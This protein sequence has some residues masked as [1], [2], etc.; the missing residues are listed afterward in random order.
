[1]YVDLVY[2]YYNTDAIIDPDLKPMT[3]RK[4]L[5]SDVFSKNK[6]GIDLLRN[7][8]NKDK[9]FNFHININ[10]KLDNRDNKNENSNYDGNNKNRKS[11]AEDSPVLNI[12]LSSQHIAINSPSTH[13]INSCDRSEMSNRILMKLKDDKPGSPSRFALKKVPEKFRG[14]N[15]F[16]TGVQLKRNS[17]KKDIKILKHEETIKKIKVSDKN[18]KFSLVGTSSYRKPVQSKLYLDSLS[19]FDQLFLS[20]HCNKDKKNFFNTIQKKI[21][22]KLSIEYLF[23]KYHEVNFLKSQFEEEIIDKPYLVVGDMEGNE[24]NTL[25]AFY[26][27][28][29]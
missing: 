8:Q 27:R 20:C 9:K 21:D 7:I 17:V 23:N 18:R 2:K 25:Y 11:K 29:K 15:D 16:S 4:S 28:K 3:H 1:M 24:R 26:N 6:N 14:D 13:K 19:Y 10:D 22:E 12:N 5:R